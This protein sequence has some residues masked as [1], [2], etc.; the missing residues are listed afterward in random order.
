VV[1]RLSLRGPRAASRTRRAWARTRAAVGA[2]IPKRIAERIVAM[3]NR[4]TPHPP[5]EL[6][7]LAHH[8]AYW[9]EKWGFDMLNPDMDEVLRRYGDTEVCW[10]YDPARRAAG[11]EILAAWSAVNSA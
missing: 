6:R 2:A 1:H 9:R 8:Y 11:E 3:E 7:R 4:G 10:A 5:H